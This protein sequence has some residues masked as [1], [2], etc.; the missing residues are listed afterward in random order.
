M[1]E[2]KFLA[3]HKFEKSAD[4]ENIIRRITGMDDVESVRGEN[5]AR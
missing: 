3:E 4:Q 1:V 5:P 2:Q